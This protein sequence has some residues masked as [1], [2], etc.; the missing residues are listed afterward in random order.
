MALAHDSL[1]AL[2]RAVGEALL[3]R[4]WRL[5]TAESCTGGGVGAAVTAIAGS[6]A[7]Y[8][9]GVI[10]Y[11]NA[12]KIKLLDVAPAL[13]DSHGAVS[14]AVAA[15]MALGARRELRVDVAVS[16]T[17]IAG[18]DGGSA[19]KPVGLVCFAWATA[20]RIE[21]ESCHFAGDREQVRAQAVGYALNGVLQRLQRA[22]VLA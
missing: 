3:T 19:S 17:G 21:A 20:E 4:G 16:V 18:P 2:G 11:S 9:G 14:E 7:W 6:S 1:L 10:S 13:L 12:L 5:G 22:D 8:E 15:A